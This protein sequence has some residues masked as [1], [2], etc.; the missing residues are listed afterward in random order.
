MIAQAA[1][2]AGMSIYGSEQKKRAAKKQYDDEQSDLD[3]QRAENQNWYMRR[4]YEDGTQRAD[5]RRI[6]TEARRSLVDNSNSIAG[7]IA[8]TGGSNAAAAAAKEKANQAYASA[9]S[10]AA[11]RADA[12]KDQIEESYRRTDSQIHAAQRQSDRYYGE[13]KQAAIT[14]AVQGLGGLVQSALSYGANAGGASAG[15][16]TGAAEAATRAANL[17]AANQQT[18]TVDPNVTAQNM[19]VLSQTRQDLTEAGR[20]AYAVKSQETAPMT[21]A[22]VQRQNAEHVAGTNP[23]LAALMGFYDA[24]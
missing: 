14:Q 9:V 20:V 12:R 4:Y 11:A 5:V 18:G 19:N 21:D 22:Q 6:L 24:Y 7:R 13:Q 8:V 16:N 23:K 2:G 10:S 1:I 17:T 15:A 3:R